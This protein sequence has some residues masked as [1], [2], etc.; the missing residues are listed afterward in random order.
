MKF[1]LFREYEIQQVIV[2]IPVLNGS[3][4]SSSRRTGSDLCL[5]LFL[6]AL[7]FMV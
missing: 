6:Y 4:R 2:Y 5:A 3:D 7:L 1:E